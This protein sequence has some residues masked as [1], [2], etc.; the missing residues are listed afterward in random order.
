MAISE[1]YEDLKT[2][3]HDLNNVLTTVIGYYNLAKEAEENGDLEEFQ[4]FK[5]K[6]YASLSKKAEKALKVSK[7]LET[8][9]NN[10]KQTI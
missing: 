1:I 8:I 4:F 9:Q 2:T 7:D 6:I 5:D 10:L 3:V